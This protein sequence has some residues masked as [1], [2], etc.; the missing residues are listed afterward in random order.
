MNKDIIWN[1]FLDKIKERISPLSYDTWF[2]DTR[3]H[4]IEGGTAIILVPMSLHKKHLEENYL[5][6]IEEIFNSITGTIFNL[7]FKLENEITQE[8]EVNEETIISTESVGVPY[9]SSVTANL[10]S[11]YTYDDRTVLGN[12]RRGGN[13]VPLLQV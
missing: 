6:E 13:S 9:Q 10:K 8:K 4:K 3:L 7:Q 2:K 5:D 12:Q 11:E 1:N